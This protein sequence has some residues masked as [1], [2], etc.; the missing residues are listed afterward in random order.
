MRAEKL[1]E[2]AADAAGQHEREDDPSQRLEAVEV[3]REERVIEPVLGGN[4]GRRRRVA[5][6]QLGLDDAH[7]DDEDHRDL[8]GPHHGTGEDARQPIEG[9]RD[10]HVQIALV[11][12]AQHLEEEDGRRHDDGV[13]DHMR[14]ER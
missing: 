3:W 10:Q 4:E 14:P 2:I 12:G 1:R 13:G 8:E 5:C 11:D 6:R 7:A 9:G